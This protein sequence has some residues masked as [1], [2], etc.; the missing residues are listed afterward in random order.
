[1]VRPLFQPE[2]LPLNG[3]LK[4]TAAERRAGMGAAVIKA[5][6]PG[7]RDVVMIFSNSGR[8]PYPVEIAEGARASG[9][10]VVAFTSVAV[11]RDSEPR[12]SQRLFEVADIVLDTC[13]PPGD[14]SRP[15]QHPVTSPM[16]TLACCAVWTEI[17]AMMAKIEPSV[18]L[19]RSANRD[20]ND[21][22]NARL[23]DQLR[24][25]IPEL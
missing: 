25:R 5:A 18:P 22:F 8:N 21:Q 14:V 3:A 10:T 1:M 9:A 23:V 20:G 4:A 13:T 24:T 16:S 17:L 6:A 12:G 11:S 15:V 19:W 7:A 2:L